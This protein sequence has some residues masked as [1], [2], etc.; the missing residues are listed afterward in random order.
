MNT[1]HQKFNLPVIT[2]EVYKL[3]PKRYQLRKG[4]MDG[5]PPCPFGHQFKWIGYDIELMRYVRVT[6]SVFKKLIGLMDKKE[7]AEHELFFKAY[8]KVL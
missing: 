2:A 7:V 3:K 6:T 4:N 8:K 1:E 5:A